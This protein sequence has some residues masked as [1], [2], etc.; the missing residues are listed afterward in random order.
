M[1]EWCIL[2]APRLL[3]EEPISSVSVSLGIPYDLLNQDLGAPETEKKTTLAVTHTVNYLCDITEGPVWRWKSPGDVQWHLR[4]CTLLEC[5]NSSECFR[6]R[7]YMSFHCLPTACP[8]PELCETSKRCAEP[9]LPLPISQAKKSSPLPVKY[10]SN[11]AWEM[12]SN[13]DFLGRILTLPG[14]SICTA[15][16]KTVLELIY[17]EPCRE[18]CGLTAIQ[19]RRRNVSPEAIPFQKSISPLWLLLQIPFALMLG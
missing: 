10:Y 8:F 15:C 1:K 7:E 13:R 17:S 16:P 19:G 9:P 5:L 11:K 2:Q 4:L 18:L 12:R 3:M 14:I 6:S